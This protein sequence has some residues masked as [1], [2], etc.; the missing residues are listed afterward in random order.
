M[1]PV[2]PDL[3]GNHSL[4][5]SIENKYMNWLFHYLTRAP[6]ALMSVDDNNQYKTMSES[7]PFY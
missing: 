6:I 4:V 7:L 2:E 5:G 3:L 1:W